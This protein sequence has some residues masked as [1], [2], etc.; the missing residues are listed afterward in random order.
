MKWRFESSY[1]T[2]GTAVRWL[3]GNHHGHSTR[4]DGLDE[5]MDI[6][7]AYEAA[8]YAY[9]ALSEHDLYVDPATYSAATTMVML[10]A[11]EVTSSIEQTLMVL[12]TDG[13]VPGAGEVSLAELSDYVGRRGGLFIVD[14]PNWLYQP[15]RKHARVQDILAAPGANA[16]EIYTGVIERLSGEAHAV[17]VWDAVLSAGQRCYGHAVDDQHR[18]VDQFLGWNC[19]QWSGDTDPSAVEIINALAAGRFYASTGVAFEKLGTDESGS[20][21]E[22]C[23]DAASVAW[24]T[25]GGV[26]VKRTL[27]GMS[28]LSIDEAVSLCRD[29]A[30]QAFNGDSSAAYIR[31]EATNEAG[32]TAWSQP[33]FMRP[34]A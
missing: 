11:V 29:A 10:P 5:P 22:V 26:E 27:G 19:V 17:D 1:E 15:G 8:G 12:G 20:H 25:C 6:I 23:G 18:D 2:L 7:K 16:I 34:V 24:I 14:H 9:L 4:S 3:K 30:P 32:K 21:A 31:A 13:D 28:T 33:F